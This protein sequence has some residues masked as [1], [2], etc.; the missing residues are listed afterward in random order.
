MMLD[1]AGNGS[2]MR[3]EETPVFACKITNQN[4]NSK[5]NIKCFLRDYASRSEASSIQ[6]R[7]LPN[8]NYLEFTLVKQANTRV[9][10]DNPTTG[11]SFM[12]RISNSGCKLKY[13]AGY[14][15]ENTDICMN[16]YKL[17]GR[18]G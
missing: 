15:G 10:I 2:V 7:R 1:D 9:F 14:V 16:I 8:R 13:R 5:I 12:F 3:L 11:I 18:Y 4:V 17:W 6:R